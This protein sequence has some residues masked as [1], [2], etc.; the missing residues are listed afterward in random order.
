MKNGFT[1]VKNREGS[2]V[3]TVSVSKHQEPFAIEEMVKYEYVISMRIKNADGK[4]VELMEEAFDG[5]GLNEKQAFDEAVGEFEKY[6]KEHLEELE[7]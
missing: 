5:T 4:T 7:F 3:L 1:F 2:R 6:L